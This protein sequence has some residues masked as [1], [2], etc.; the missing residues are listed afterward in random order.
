MKELARIEAPAAPPWRSL[1]ERSVQ[2]SRIAIDGKTFP[3]RVRCFDQELQLNGAGLCEWGIFGFDLYRAAL[4]SEAP[5]RTTEAALAAAEDQV[6]VV[7]LD[8]V[9]RLSKAQLEQA[10]SASVKA[11]TGEQF[12][13]FEAPLAELLETMKEVQDGD[14]YT[15]TVEPD[16]G[17]WVQRDGVPLAKIEDPE[18]GRLFV[19]LYVG[20]QPPTKA[21]REGLLGGDR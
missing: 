2:L 11:N 13:R 19:R 18:F 15:F 20:D 8:F 12:P 6:I 17:V 5:F 9:R 10:Y 3:P 4:Y 21:L 14:S 1:G 16:V 7:H